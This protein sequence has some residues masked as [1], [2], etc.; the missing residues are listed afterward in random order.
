MTRTEYLEGLRDQLE[1]PVW[2][3]LRELN[4]TLQGLAKTEHFDLD[5]DAA[6]GSAIHCALPRAVE[7]ASGKG[8]SAISFKRSLVGPANKI[9]GTVDIG[10][11]PKPF[12]AEFHIA[13]PKG[14]T[15]KEAHQFAG[16]DEQ[17]NGCLFEEFEDIEDPSGM[18]LLFVAYWL[19]PSRTTV[20]RAWLVFADRVSK[21][22]IELRQ[23]ESGEFAKA[24]SQPETPQESGKGAALTLKVKDQ[25]VKKDDGRKN[26]RE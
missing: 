18:L 16:L 10:G 13:G 15:G 17:W 6:M 22:K 8:G 5:A 19:S 7:A 1:V 11:G 14:G 25:G 20:A 23:I 3:V 24:D 4:R 21:E 9:V 2:T 26:Q 12:S